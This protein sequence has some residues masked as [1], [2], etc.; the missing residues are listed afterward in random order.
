MPRARILRD[1]ALYDIANRMPTEIGQLAELR[2]LSD[3][4]ARSSR[5]KD[6]VAAVSRALERDPKTVPQLPRNA[7]SSPEAGALSTCCAFS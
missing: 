5:A 3:G 2:T 1:E 7:Q 4:F 6:I